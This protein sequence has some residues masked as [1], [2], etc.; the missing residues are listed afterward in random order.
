[1]SNYGHIPSLISALARS[2]GACGTIVDIAEV[3]QAMLANLKGFI[4][5]LFGFNQNI[6]FIY[7]IFFTWLSERIFFIFALK[8][9]E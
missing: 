6:I 8:K 5:I 2:F 7:A 9:R 1:V 3:C 4:S